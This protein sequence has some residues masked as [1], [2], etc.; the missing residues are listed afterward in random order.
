M[1][2]TTILQHWIL[3]DFILPFSLIFFLVFAVLEK[4]KLL[5]DSNKQLN[6]LIAFV[7]GVIFVGVAKPKLIVSNMILFLTVA[8]VMMFVLLLLWGFV[9][10]GNDGFTLETC[11]KYILWAV[12]GVAF[13]IAVLWAT[14]VKG[15]AFNFLF[16]QSW[17][18]TF[19][20][21]LA[22]IAAIVIALVL[23]M[24]NSK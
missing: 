1:A 11:M 4:T 10:A 20:T 15:D 6:A 18:E 3:T 12:V 22:F 21:N 5:G 13:V 24:R 14:G 19:W 8:L 9:S 23:V 7:I 2:E 16:G 17:S